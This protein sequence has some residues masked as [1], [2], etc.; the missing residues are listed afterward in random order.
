MGTTELRTE[1]EINAPV[2]HVY[3]VLTDFERYHEWNPFIPNIAGKLQVGQALAL[4][5]SLPEGNTYRLKPRIT[6]LT[7]NAELRWQGSYLFPFLL[8]AEHFFLLTGRGER[9]TRFV[10]GEN[11]SGLLLRFAGN[12]LTLTARGFVYMNQALKKR[13][14]GSQ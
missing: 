4:E 7:E 2:A 6:Q 3:R 9:L 10:Q 5:V 1:V 11:F 12:T 14:E 8:N 13:A